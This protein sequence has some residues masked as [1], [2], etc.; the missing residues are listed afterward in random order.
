MSDSGEKCEHILMKTVKEEYVVFRK[1]EV[2][3]LSA[4]THAPFHAS[5]LRPAS[6]VGP[7]LER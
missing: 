3:S 6:Q 4:V 2:G 7:M 5:V 1:G